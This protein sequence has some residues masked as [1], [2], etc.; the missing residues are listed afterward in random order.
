MDDARDA[1]FVSSMGAEGRDEVADDQVRGLFG[2]GALELLD[3]LAH[4]LS[5]VAA[6]HVLA[7]DQLVASDVIGINQSGLDTVFSGELGGACLLVLVGHHNNL[8]AA[9]L[10]GVHQAGERDK[11]AH[12]TDA[13]GDDLQLLTLLQSRVECLLGEHTVDWTG[14]IRCGYVHNY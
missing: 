9:L 10:E 7:L 1:K 14:D 11:V 13:S 12:F 8:V 4:A 6:G 5:E 2:D 3:K